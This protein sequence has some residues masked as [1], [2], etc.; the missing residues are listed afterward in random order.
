LERIWEEAVLALS[1]YYLSICPEEL[2]KTMKNNR[3][4]GVPADIK[5]QSKKH[6]AKALL[7]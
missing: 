5:T 6:E 3:L 2:R 1:K 7:I 4:T